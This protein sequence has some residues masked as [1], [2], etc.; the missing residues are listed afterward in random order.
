MVWGGSLNKNGSDY[1]RKLSEAEKAIKFL[2]NFKE[3]LNEKENELVS[4]TID[5]I[6]KFFT[7][8]ENKGS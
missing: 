4:K 6:I 2:E 5:I 8:E 7:K 3:E 1:I